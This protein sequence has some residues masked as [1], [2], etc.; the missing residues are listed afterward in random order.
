MRCIIAFN[1][2]QAE[3]QTAVEY[4]RA[5]ASLDDIRREL[6]WSAYNVQVDYLY[7][8]KKYKAVY[9]GLPTE[10]YPPR[11][12]MGLVLLPGLAAARLATR[13]HGSI[14]ATSRVRKYMGPDLDF[15]AKQGLV[16]RLA[17]M[18]P[19][20]DAE[21]SAETFERLDIVLTDGSRHS[22]EY[23]ANPVMALVKSR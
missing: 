13:K 15:H 7:R 14:D 12:D 21:S 19:W 11:R 20:D 8:G 3:G 17:D 18:F 1:E 6:Q 16:V 4:F 22:F 2:S 5:D 10:K 23:A 9:R